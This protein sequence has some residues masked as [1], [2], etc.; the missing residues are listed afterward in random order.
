[1]T[2]AAHTTAHGRGSRRDSNA[3]VK[4]A[5][6]IPIQQSRRQSSPRHSSHHYRST[7]SA[8]YFRRSSQAPTRGNMPSSIRS[9]RKIISQS[10]KMW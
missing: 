10:R 9:F 8:P 3:G 4:Q 5:L 6:Q 2:I 7:I 1:M